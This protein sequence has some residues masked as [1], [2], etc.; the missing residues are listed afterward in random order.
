MK[1]T[2]KMVT[3]DGVQYTRKIIEM[4]EEL[5][6]TTKNKQRLRIQNEV[7]DLED[8]VADNAKWASILTTFIS[9]IY[10]ILPEEQKA[11]LDPTERATIEYA[12]A[13]FAA[14]NTRADVMLAAEGA[15]GIKKLLD[16]QGAIG[17]LVG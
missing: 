3:K 6:I 10:S 11:L 8:S 13:E 16:R 1:Y 14:T 2:E 4:P 5:T 15:A 17:T 12:L 7:F 9:R